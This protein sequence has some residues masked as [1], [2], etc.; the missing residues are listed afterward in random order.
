[1]GLKAFMLLLLSTSYP[2]AC[3]GKSLGTRLYCY[4]TKVNFDDKPATSAFFSVNLVFI[5]ISF[6]IFLLLLNWFKISHT[7][8]Q[9]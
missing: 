5:K 4:Q 8:T 9:S 3:E 6:I 2:G 7:I 1:M